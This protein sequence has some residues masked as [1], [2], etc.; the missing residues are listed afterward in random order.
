MAVRAAMHQAGAAALT[1]LLQFPEPAAD[2]RVIACPCGHEARY[3]ALRS[4]RLLTVLGAVE[5]SRP[6][7][8]CSHCHQGQFPVDRQLDVEN[9]D[10]SPGVRRMQALV[11]QEAPFDH[12]REQMKILAGLE[13]TAK[14][15]ERSAEAIGADIAEVEQGEI[16]K[17]VQLDLPVII[18]EPVPILYVQ[19]DGTGVPVVKKETEGRKGKTDGQPAHTREVKLGC[20]FTQTTWDEEGYAIRDHDS[21]TYTG[22]I[23]TAEDFGKRIYLEAWNRGWSRA[24]KKVVMGDGAEW[25]WNLADQHFPGAVQIVHLKLSLQLRSQPLTATSTLHVTETRRHPL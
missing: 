15:V 1:Q 16:Y 12:G 8:F 20:V 24:E 7:Y 22:A 21:T 11:G 3:R 9:R 25:I 23:E 17:A 19:M 18:G 14:S 2:E 13:V 4:R 6:W 5:L 10:F